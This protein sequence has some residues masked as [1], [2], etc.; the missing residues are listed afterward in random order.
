MILVT[1]LYTISIIY[2]LSMISPQLEC[3]FLYVH[4]LYVEWIFIA[5]FSHQQ[6]ALVPIN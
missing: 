3:K 1:F 6:S 4:V 5:F 2:C